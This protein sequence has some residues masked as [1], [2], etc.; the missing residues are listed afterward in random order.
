MIYIEWPRRQAPLYRIACAAESGTA[1][2]AKGN[3]HRLKS[4]ALYRLRCLFWRG[5]I[6]GNLGLPF[7]A[8]F[9]LSDFRFRCLSRKLTSHP[10]SFFKQANAYLDL[11]DDPVHTDW[12]ATQHLRL[13][14][15]GLPGRST[16]Q[17]LSNE[18]MKAPLRNT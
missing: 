12:Q 13:R 7:T 16:T 8:S 17:K 9:S 2:L 18:V 11:V 15:A 10:H 5:H 3:S 14:V 1:R 4:A 6:C